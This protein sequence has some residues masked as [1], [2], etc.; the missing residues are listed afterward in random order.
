MSFEWRSKSL[1]VTTAHF[2]YSLYLF[3]APCVFHLQATGTRNKELEEQLADV[4]RR[5]ETSQVEQENFRKSLK[6]LLD[7]L[8]TKIFELTEMRDNL[9]KLIEDS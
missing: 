3:S 2:F 8:D 1:H 6:T 9:A 4:E 5:L 7:I